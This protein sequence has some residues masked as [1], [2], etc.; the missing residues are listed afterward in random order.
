[1]AADQGVLVALGAWTGQF[2]S[3]QG[4]AASWQDAFKARRGLL[5]EMPRPA[6][7]APVRH[8][9]MEVGYT[10]HYTMARDSTSGSS[11]SSGSRSSGGS[12]GDSGASSGSGA[13]K[14]L[15]ITF[16]ATTSAA[17]SLLIGSSREFVGLE[18][19]GEAPGQ[20]VDAILQRAAQFLP[21]VARVER[22][23]IAVRAGPRPYS[24]VGG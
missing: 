13:L 7:M 18:A 6:G 1:V 9:L 11:S 16:T 19:A 4:L 10:S 5:L 20:V 17:G 8:G 22:G 2:L 15:D 12:N 21:A 23:S 14:E 24:T 3:Q